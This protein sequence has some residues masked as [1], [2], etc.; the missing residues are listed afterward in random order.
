[1]LILEPELDANS[2]VQININ[3][4]LVNCRYVFMCCI[5]ILSQG[6]RSRCGD[7]P[8]TSARTLICFPF[9]DIQ[10]FRANPFLF[11]IQKL[12]FTILLK[13]EFFH[14]ALHNTRPP[15]AGPSFLS[16]FFG[17]PMRPRYAEASSPPDTAE[18]SSCDFLMSRKNVGGSSSD[19]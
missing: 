19:T 16:H 7:Y 17:D 18:A 2:T 8:S 14:M 3:A 12:N 9:A 11:V 13:C 15:Q 6:N 4:I 5:C 10:N 1:M